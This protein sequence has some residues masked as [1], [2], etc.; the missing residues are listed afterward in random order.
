MI[1]RYHWLP[2][3]IAEIPYRKMQDLFLII[4]QKEETDEIK[5]NTEK[6]KREAKQFASSK[7][8]SK[9]SYREV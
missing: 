6:A 3:D 7:G 1:E 8:K 5:T 4:N 9:K 2:K